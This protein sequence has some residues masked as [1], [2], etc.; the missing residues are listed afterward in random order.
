MKNEERILNK[1]CHII[2][3]YQKEEIILTQIEYNQILKIQQKI[4]EMLALE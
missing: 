4:L 3:E 1:D 2:K